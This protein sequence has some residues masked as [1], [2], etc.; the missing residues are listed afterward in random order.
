MSMGEFEKA[1]QDFEELVRLDPQSWIGLMNLMSAH[2][3]LGQFGKARGVWERARAHNLD[4]PRFHRILLE[5]ALMQ[6]DEAGSAQEIKWFEGRHDEF[7]SLESQASKAIVFGQR[8][9]H[10]IC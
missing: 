7:L 2:V 3:S 5:V 10:R 9:R 8:R 4:A 6:N 1:K